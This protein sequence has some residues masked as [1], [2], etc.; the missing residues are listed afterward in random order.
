V[1]TRRPDTDPTAKTLRVRYTELL[2]LRED[3]HRLISCLETAEPKQHR[4][5][6]ELIQQCESEDSVVPSQHFVID[7]LPCG[8]READSRSMKR[9][10]C[11]ERCIHRARQTRGVRSVLRRFDRSR[12]R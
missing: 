1:K 11:S 6:A 3:V 4:A 7:A 10:V 5:P 12:P 2:Q 8:R 9:V